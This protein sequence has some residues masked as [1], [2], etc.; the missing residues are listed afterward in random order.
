MESSYKE[1]PDASLL[2]E[3]GP[4][5]AVR[6][7]R[8]TPLGVAAVVAVGVLALCG[9]A[10][11]VPRPSAVVNLA[12]VDATR[13]FDDAGRFIMRSFD[14]F[15]PMASFLPGVGG[16]WGVPMWSFYVNRGQGIA[17]FGVENKD[18]GFLLFQSAE[19]AYTYTPYVGFRTLV[20]G[21]R[22]DGTA[23]ESQPFFPQSD[24]DPDTTARR[25]MYI[26]NNEMEIEESDPATG[27]RT[28]VLYFTAV[29]ETFPALVR[30]VTFT[31][32]GSSS[33]DLEVVD[34]LAKLEPAGTQILQ[35]ETIGRT[36]EGWMHVY[37]FGEGQRT[38]PFFHLVTAPADT[39]D[40][41]QIKEGHFAAA[42]VEGEG[43][44]LP[45]I[46]DQQLVFGT[47][48]TLAV[49]RR[50][51]SNSNQPAG[52]S[53]AELTS[54]PQ[55]IT[56]RTPAAFAAATLK[57]KPGESKTINLVYGHSPDLEG[58]L[59]TILP[60]ISAKA[61]VASQH[62][63]SQ[64]LGK[65]LTK[66]ASMRSAIP[67]F[68]NY[69]S[70]NYLD[71]L[72][73][74]G[75]PFELGAT[76]G[77]APKI[78]H[79]FSRIHGDLERDYNNFVIEPSFWSQGPGA[80]RDVAQN[81]RCDVLQLPSVGDFNVR[82][83]F[84]MIQADGYNVLTVNTQFFRI[85]NPADVD[86]LA[87]KVAAPSSVAKMKEILA[88]PFRPGLL[89]KNIS[90]SQV[91]T[92]VPKEELLD[93]VTAKAEQ[94]PAG[95]YKVASVGVQGQNG[96]W[97]DHFTY[98]LDLITNFVAVYPDKK[99]YMLF[100]SDPI[101]Y[102]ISPVR[103]V[104]RTEKNMIVT[105][106]KIRQYD[107]FAMSP[108]K[109]AQLETMTK[110]PGFCGDAGG[111]GFWQRTAKGGVMKVSIIAKLVTLC[112]TKFS[113]MDPL[114]M[115]VEMEGG[116]P[117]WNDAMNG[118]PAL[119]G[120]EM[121]SAYELHELIDFVGVSVDE[122]SREVTMPE[123][124]GGL[125]T[126]IEA[127]LAA[128]SSGKLSSFEYWDKAHDAVEAYRSATETTFSGGM[129]S[130]DAKRLGGGS[131]LFGA[132]LSRLDD[133]VKRAL[134]YATDPDRSVS[135]TYFRFAVGSYKEVGTSAR[136]LKTIQVQSWLEPEAL[137]HFLEGPVR[138]LKTLKA[139][140]VS[141]KERVYNAVA[142]SD[143]FDTKLKM[144]KVSASLAAQPFE[145][146]RMKAFDSGWLENE[147]IWLHMSYKWLLELLRAGL[148]EQFF[149]D[150]KLGAVCFMD[151]AV[152]GR[153]PLE[154][155]SFI[156]S[157][158]FP[159]P[160]LHGTGFQ[161]RLSG[162]TAEFLSMWNHMMTGATPFTLDKD[163]SLQLTLSPVIPSWMWREDG[164]VTFS[165][166][167]DIEVTY[168]STSKADS[169]KSTV[170]GYEL[171]GPSGV[172]HVDGPAVP[173][174]TAEA[175]RSLKFTAIKVRLN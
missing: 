128:L 66:R 131:G 138:H 58:Y 164:T 102:Y 14:R 130:W 72:L 74:G 7:R 75:M 13:S 63:A 60:K 20:K 9:V 158:A 96:F 117:G 112:A 48:T 142:A 121:P 105:A 35:I 69:V 32:E 29:D 113:I 62:L 12:A 10:S 59:A 93:L 38:A 76:E 34:G 156:V 70:Q 111:S 24:S 136:G 118:L 144:Y 161:A 104:N 45:M 95:Q 57:L 56:S 170:Q 140:S 64:E 173:M 154:A 41:V 115:G 43:G 91:E 37:N 152:L 87:A 100:D 31:N 83:F 51:F 168:I 134:T 85:P 22:E 167:G 52:S 119:F 82:Q 123:E 2:A 71:N 17:T 61:F 77:V 141:A 15:K 126:S 175:V 165:F 103:I 127:N 160:S 171:V 163:G 30:R 114:G 54:A 159:D 67:Q 153:S 108:A 155:A 116:K 44:L 107:A 3:S 21:K 23:F 120:S 166:L 106:E 36:L 169:W 47:D 174:P 109:A 1:F 78:Y 16:Q 26:G 5:P 124:V 8:L 89:F 73:R 122:A 27:I 101:P 28:N 135:P 19:K 143:L 11:Q 146:G 81:R 172:T 145:V 133:G 97:V 149:K 132:M 79:T 147:S 25:D 90:Q 125:L 46:C 151:P 42:Y 84:S 68:D 157:S 6:A 80:F 49:P 98:L 162:T 148:Y 129:V 92:L 99:E 137:P 86:A 110:E 55:S 94:V 4:A 50:F 40:V 150:L 33:V 18:G 65:V 88:Q 53:I 39:A 139:Q